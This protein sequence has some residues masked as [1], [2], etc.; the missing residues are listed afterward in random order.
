MSG[1]GSRMTASPAALDA[2]SPRLDVLIPTYRRK[3]GLAMTLTSLLGQSWRGFDVTIADQTP[4][5]ERYTDDIELRTVCEALR[6]HGHRVTVHP[7]DERLGLAEQREFLLREASAP[8]VHYLDDDVLL[9]P[10]TIERMVRV[11]LE[12]R[13]GFVGAAAAGLGYLGDV[14]PHETRYFEP[15]QGRV[16]PEPFA[17]DA[18]PW[19][20]HR[21]NSAANALHLEREFAAGGATVRYKVAWV[22]GANVLYDRAKL[23]AVGGFGF[24]RRLP[25]EHAGEDALVQFLLLERYGGCGVL[26]CGT[27][28]LCLPT[29]VEDRAV[30]ATELYAEL[31]ER[32]R[33][34]AR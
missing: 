1:Y 17:P 15:W 28:H 10:G 32:A 14:R 13:C 16:E 34:A 3:T 19:D 30:N 26:P 31:R 2:P 23:L 5:H 20:R 4:P 6:W 11:M 7:R 8:F 25:R 12:E 29:T 18:I 21:V 24:W 27:Y 9:D 33:D 22:G